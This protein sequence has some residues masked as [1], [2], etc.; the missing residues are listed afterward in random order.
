MEI[1]MN[2]QAKNVTKFVTVCGSMDF[3]VNVINGRQCVDGRS[4]I[5]VM[6]MCGH[7]VTIAPVTDDE[8][9]IERF[10]RK[11]KPLGAYKTEGFYG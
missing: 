4:V 6:E 2:L 9:E 5:G 10:F 11:I 7:I 3:D 1:R 8:I